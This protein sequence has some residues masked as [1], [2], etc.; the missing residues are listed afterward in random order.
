MPFAL[1]EKSVSPR[2]LWRDF[3]ELSL[4]ELYA[5]LHLRQQ[6][7]VVEQHC[8][9][10]DADGLDDRAR[11]LLA[12][13][14]DGLAGYLRV[15]APTPSQPSWIVSRVVVA[16]PC[17]GAGLARRMMGEALAHAAAQAPGAPVRLS[18]Q[19]YLV[20]FY[21]DLGFVPEGPPYDEDG[22]PHVP[23]VLKP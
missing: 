8:P 10:L 16:A 12:W 22:I 14:D 15:H 23:M 3:G 5:V 13:G 7:F 19:A 9:F 1:N 17:R 6:V 2:G 11:H 20:G 18:A 4:T 21:A